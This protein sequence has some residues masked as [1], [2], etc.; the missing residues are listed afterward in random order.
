M[1]ICDRCGPVPATEQIRFKTTDERKDLCKSC[2]EEVR[3]FIAC[4]PAELKRA[5]P[6]EFPIN[7]RRESGFSL[8]KE[9]G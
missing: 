7:Y 8:H 6:S 3:E 1:R 4:K 5:D 2:S 9:G